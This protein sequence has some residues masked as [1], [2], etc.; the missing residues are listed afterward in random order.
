MRASG[1][2]TGATSGGAINLL[3]FII[4]Y[5]SGSELLKVCNKRM[6]M[7]GAPSSLTAI[8]RSKFLITK[9]TDFLQL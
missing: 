3:N 8:D 6:T 4:F 5:L 7:S 9:I 2:S 1:V